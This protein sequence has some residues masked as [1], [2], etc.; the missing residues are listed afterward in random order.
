MVFAAKG[1]EMFRSGERTP[2]HLPSGSNLCR[3]GLAEFGLDE[4]S[5]TLGVTQ[6]RYETGRRTSWRGRAISGASYAWNRQCSKSGL[7]YSILVD[8]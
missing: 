3:C 1:Q 5:D 8:Q 2:H 6:S 4:L 7:K